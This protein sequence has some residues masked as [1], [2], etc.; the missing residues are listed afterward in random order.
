MLR[1]NIKNVPFVFIT[2]MTAFAFPTLVIAQHEEKDNVIT[3]IE[4]VPYTISKP[5]NYKLER[6][7]QSDRNGIE[8]LASNVIID[9]NQNTINGPT[10]SDN[11]GFGIFSFGQSNITI[12]NGLIRGFQYGVYLSGFSDLAADSSTLKGR[13]HSVNN[14]DVRFSTFRGI[15]VEGENSVISDNVISDIGGDTTI[16]NAYAMGIET[17]GKEILIQ[18]NSIMEVRGQ[19]IQDIG[20]GVGISLS[21][22]GEGSVVDNNRIANREF[23]ISSSSPAWQNRSR[24]TYGIWVGGDGVQDIVISN[25]TIN[26][27]K[28][29]ITFKRS[30]SGSFSGNR[31]TNAFIPYYLP[32]NQERIR[33]VDLGGNTS[34]EQTLELKP[35]RATPGQIETV[36]PPY[37]TYLSPLHRHSNPAFLPRPNPTNGDDIIIG[38]GER[39]MVDY[40]SPIDPSKPD[41]PV[42]IDLMAG[43]AS[44]GGGNDRLINIRGAQGSS[45]DDIILGDDHDNLLAGGS[46]NDRIE[47]MEGND[48]LYGD[49]GNDVLFGGPGDDV[50]DGGDGNDILWGGSGADTFIFWKGSGGGETIIGDFSGSVGEQDKIDLAGILATFEDVLDASAEVGDDLLITL[51]ADDSILLLNMKKEELTPSDFIF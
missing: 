34:D 41:S 13:N 8:I 19:G 6:S 20:E 47:G 28:Q 9:L 42:F 29:G 15:R 26:N 37:L 7:L 24:S 49:D 46:G 50:L 31:V 3:L 30:E 18:N 4:S 32:E 45:Y 12:K 22:Y 44:G 36:E 1:L 11:I 35:G 16:E 14:M 21:R 51:N 25:N 23:E 10:E 48:Y 39:N 33:V 17:Y 5:G 2:I 40:W 27:F 43:R 38:I